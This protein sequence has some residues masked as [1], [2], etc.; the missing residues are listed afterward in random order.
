MAT[1]FANDILKCIYFN[2][3]DRFPIQIPLK[4]VPK[5]PI[6]NSPALG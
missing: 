6:D 3:S 1:I 2:E 4:F 5:C